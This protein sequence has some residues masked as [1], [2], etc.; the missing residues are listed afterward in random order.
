MCAPNNVQSFLPSNASG[1]L[2][3]HWQGSKRELRRLRRAVRRNCQCQLAAGDAH[4]PDCDA[5]A[6][7]A[8]QCILDHLLYVYRERSRFVRAEF[9]PSTT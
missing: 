3:S 6:L 2:E 4:R 8:D 7:L 5:N 1:V 9:A